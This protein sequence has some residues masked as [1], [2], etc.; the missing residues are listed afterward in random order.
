MNQLWCDGH[1]GP[2]KDV[3]WDP[4]GRL[5]A[6]SLEGVEVRISRTADWQSEGTIS[7]PSLDVVDQM[8]LMCLSWSPD[9][10]HIA[11]L[12]TAKED[13]QTVRLINQ[14][15]WQIGSDFVGHENQLTCVEMMSPAVGGKDRCFSVWKTSGRHALD[16]EQ[17][18]KYGAGE[19]LAL[20]RQQEEL[21]PKMGDMPVDASGV[22]TT[23]TIKWS[24]QT[25]WPNLLGTIDCAVEERLP[26]L[27]KTSET[28]KI[29]YVHSPS[30]S[31]AVIA[32]VQKPLEVPTAE[33]R[34]NM[35]LNS[36]RS[37]MLSVANN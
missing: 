25:E 34:G 11:A 6:T 18:R 36:T 24:T 3:P 4:T 10:S 17:G 26:T 16:V 32:P 5:L 30:K 8:A 13:F 37:V 14:N 29:A 35:L 27:A 31:A 22:K 12:H 2:V 1:Q 7:S 28:S 9:G 20:Q 21:R 33:M 15:W 19:V 23:A